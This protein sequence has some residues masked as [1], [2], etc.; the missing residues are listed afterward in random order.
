MSQTVFV[1]VYT[2]Y[3]ASLSKSKY[4]KHSTSKSKNATIIELA[5]QLYNAS[6]FCSEVTSITPLDEKFL[7]TNS[8]PG[9]YNI[10]SSG[11]ALFILR[12]QN[13]LFD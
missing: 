2:I 5:L 13:K 1:Y 9:G 6:C 4:V 8:C 10:K 7:G 11:L 12:L 3:E